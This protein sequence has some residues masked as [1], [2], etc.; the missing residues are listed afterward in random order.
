MSAAQAA[1]NYDEPLWIRRLF[2]RFLRLRAV[3]LCKRHLAVIYA[4]QC[5]C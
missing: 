5:Y 2:F 3:P 4:E 1:L